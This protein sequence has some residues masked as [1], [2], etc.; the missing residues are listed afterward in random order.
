VQLKRLD[1]L[2]NKMT[3]GIKRKKCNTFSHISCIKSAETVM[4]APLE[5]AGG[6]MQ[7]HLCVCIV[8]YL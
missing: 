6:H 8:S 2:K 1:Q 3:V 5:L 7:A 4:E